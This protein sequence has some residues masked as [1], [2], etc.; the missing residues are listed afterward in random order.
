M[1][2]YFT[3]YIMQRS[4]IYFLLIALFCLLNIGNLKSQ[5]ISNMYFLDNSPLRHHYNPSLQPV[6]TFYLDFPLLGNLQYNIN[7]DF[8]T[9]KNAG[10]AS[11]HILN[12]EN[13]KTQY[14][15]AFKPISNLYA[16]AF[17][18]LIDI[19]FRHN[20]N[21]WTFSIAQRGDVNLNLPK[22][23]ID[24]YANGLQLTDGYVA[25]FKNFNLS[26][27][28]Y[29]ESAFGY[30]RM[31]NEKIGFGTKIKLLYGNNHFNIDVDKA[32]FNYSANTVRSQADITVVKASAFDIDDKFKLVKPAS[33][34]QY[35]LP[36]GF[37]G[38]LDFGMNYKP[39]PNLTLAA[40]VTDLG[41]L[42][43]T[44]RQSVKYGL[45]YIFDEDDAIAWKNNHA[46]FTDVPSDSILADIRS[47]LTANRS[48]LP[49]VMNYLAPKLNVSAEFGVLKNVISFGVLSRSIY[50]E[51]KFLHELTTA[52]NL[53]PIKWLNLALSY[54]VT[55]G[56]A[57][58][59]G[60]GANVRTGIFNIF[61]SADYIPFRT[62]GLDLQQFNPQ[63][64]SFA[65]PLGY[66]NDRVNMAIG[67]NI[68]IGTHKDT[69][70]DGISDKF[71]RCPDTPFGVKVD[72]RGCPVDSD[73]DGVPDYLDL[74]PN[75]PKE[76]RAF[77]GPDGCPLDTDGDG[78]P[79]YLDKCPDSSPLAR[80]FVDE[81]GCPIDT[82]QDG[83]FDY[84]DKCPD[85]PIGI[86]VDSVGCPIDTDND[87][88]PDYLDLCPDSPAAARGFVDANGCLLDSDDDGIPDYL[89][90]CP[91]T[92]IEARG[93]V[94]INGCLIDADDDGVPDYRD[95]CPD[96]P[97]D[98]RESVD[99]RGCPKDSD[100]DGIPDY[101]DDCPKVPGLP[102]Y[103]GCPEPV[104]RTGNKDEDTSTE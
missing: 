49:G 32:D 28:T 61:L 9:F 72:S 35:I 30:S 91:D 71:D 14:T 41:L 59:F 50:R 98:A 65:F 42:Q 75:T 8:P 34:F 100:F 82:D 5:L 77:V 44:K 39:I 11:N 16:E 18:S 4:H 96:T 7:T 20:R 78:V 29:T 25:D 56:K 89:D 10:F 58:T 27:N 54:S 23:F 88:V 102:E 69:D 76:A 90:L 103:N 79:D 31:I 51:N 63:I 46:D 37:G 57:S 45:D 85:T 80:G 53:R 66:Q 74:C 83:V 22:S 17:V 62:I 94:D 55:D 87:G 21:Y 36:E 68:G 99:H 43:W 38:A 104:L 70:K 13:D 6:S 1:C 26:L 12:I 92:P 73:K 97:F 64:P 24:V 47:N 93:Y 15:S 86:A 95:D 60:L 84:M 48:D 3:K 2:V 81:N 19:G 52:L 33:F 67:F 101:L 40:A